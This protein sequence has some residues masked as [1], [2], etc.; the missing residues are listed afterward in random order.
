MMKTID[1][2]DP[3]LRPFLAAMPTTSYDMDGLRDRR[4]MP[5]P[6]PQAPPNPDLEVTER[7]V[8]G[9][10]GPEDVRVLVYRPTN[11]AAPLPAI[12]H[13]HGG[14]YIVGVPEMDDAY[15]RGYAAELGC[16]IVSVDYRLAPEHPFPA[17]LEDCYAALAWLHGEADALGVDRSRIAVKG[18]SAGGGLAAGL[19]LL[20]RDRGEIALCHQCLTA[21]MIDDRT[22][23][24]EPHDF[25]GEFVWTAESN[26]FGWACYLGQEP[27]GDGISAHAAPSRAENLAGLPATFICVGNLDLFLEENLDYVRRLGRAGVPVEFHVYPG[28]FH[29]FR[30]AG[31]TALHRRYLADVRAALAGAFRR[32]D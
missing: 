6:V 16:L 31:D 15:N 1:L 24:A 23:L 4:A 21:P 29:G 7:F 25:A 9:P 2:V 13:I 3:E 30:M 20:A 10:A 11:L 12:L 17:P 14:G 27:G 26:R 28:A 22:V 19:A 8:P 18:E 32:P 5:L